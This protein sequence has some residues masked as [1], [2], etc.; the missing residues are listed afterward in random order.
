M[1]IRTR[2]TEDKLDTLRRLLGEN[3]PYSEI[4][5]AMGITEGNLRYII[6][7]YTLK[8][9]GR[10][11]ALKK[12]RK[13]S[14]AERI[15]VLRGEAVRA[16]APAAEF[17]D[18]QLRRWLPETNGIEGLRM[19]CVE[20]LKMELQPYQ[21]EMASLMLE[22]K[23]T[24]FVLGRQSGKD[25]TT[26]C[27]VIWESI[28]KPNS[29]TLIVSP[30]QRQSDL[31]YERMAQH[32]AGSNELYD[33]V[34]ESTRECMK[35]RNGSIIKSYPSTTF[36]RGETEVTRVI[37][38]EARDF[39]NGE[40]VLASVTPMLG[41]MK[42]SLTIMSSPAGCSGI[43]WDSFN[44]PTFK[45][46]QLPSSS[47]KYLAPEWLEEQKRTVPAQTFQMEFDAQFSEAIDNFF[48]SA[49]LDKITQSYHYVSAPEPNKTYYLGIDWGRI[50][51][52]SVLTVISKDEEKQLRVEKILELYRVPFTAQLE[53]VRKLHTDFKF[54][55]IVPEKNGL[56][57]PLCEKLKEMHLPTEDFEPTLTAKS[58]G[59]GVLIKTMEDG[60]LTIPNDV[61]LQ[62]QLRTFRFEMTRGGQM[63]LHHASAS[64]NDDYCDSLML[65]V[66]AANES[67]FLFC[68]VEMGGPRLPP[69][70]PFGYY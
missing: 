64:G 14:I 52:S 67:K 4:A 2:W 23:R 55:K 42:G 33:S 18:D 40:D 41:I 17:T 53:H 68:F 45:T 1:A 19:F 60:R 11:T 54:S 12:T 26:A 62:Y 7:A 29:K 36:I 49:L 6:H 28:T 43:L 8:G 27:F 9:E 34:K 20:V 50:H 22:S 37:L 61:R 39:Q 63:K 66:H 32:I 24:C 38:N 25:F 46:M 65:A 5:K 13:E 21:L 47:N 15:L 31:L 44:N 57:M 3:K 48:S 51:D 69:A 70:H 59:Y 16:D 56:S 58:E 10:V 30:A 35:F